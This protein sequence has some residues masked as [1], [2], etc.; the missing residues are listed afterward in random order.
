M[1]VLLWTGCRI[2]DLTILGRNY[3]CEVDGVEALRW[4]PLKKGSSELASP[5]RPAQ[6][7]GPVAK[8]AGKHLCAGQ[9]LQA[10]FERRQRVPHVQAL[11]QDAGL[12]HLSAHGVQ[13]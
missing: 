5:I 2:E 8:G 9:G 4:V 12:G 10:V 6:R 13:K 7:C 3:E 11:C 1:F